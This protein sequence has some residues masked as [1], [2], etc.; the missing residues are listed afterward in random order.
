MSIG[1]VTRAMAVAC[2]FGGLLATT[3]GVCAQPAAP[4]A[5]A[6]AAADNAVIRE[7]EARLATAFVKKDLVFLDSV[8][9]E[10]VIYVGSDG[11]RMNKSAYLVL[12][13]KDRVYSSY[14]N[15][16]MVTRMYGDFA[17]VSGPE[18]VAGEFGGWK[19]QVDVVTTRVWAHR[20]NKWQIVLWQATT[21]PAPPAA[22]HSLQKW[23]HGG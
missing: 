18:K 6:A 4:A 8:I 19:G 7:L 20:A 16:T 2:C 14:V 3:V 13:T 15:K 11:A 12:V 17:V 21:A 10:D 1:S 23:L 22:P 9:A 5:P